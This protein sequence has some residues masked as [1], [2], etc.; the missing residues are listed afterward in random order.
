ME[1]VCQFR[2]QDLGPIRRDNRR[3]LQLWYM[4]S[5]VLMAGFGILIASYALGILLWAKHSLKYDLLSIGLLLVVPSIRQA[6]RSLIPPGMDKELSFDFTEEGIGM[7][8]AGRFA[9]SMVHWTKIARL[10]ETPGYFLLYSPEFSHVSSLFAYRIRGSGVIYAVPKRAMSVE[11]VE[12]LR[13]LVKANPNPLL[14][15]SAVTLGKA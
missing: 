9:S 12:Q 14:R 3:F 13:S 1:V 7:S 4:R 5:D 8:A 10:A 15:G 11:Q 2:P 6:R